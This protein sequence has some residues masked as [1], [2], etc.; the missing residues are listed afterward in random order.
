M[1]DTKF[2][3]KVPVILIITLTKFVIYQGWHSREKSLNF[4]GIPGPG[5]I[6]I[7]HKIINK[8]IK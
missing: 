4:C 2:C 1:D 6:I 8:L 5:I 3:S 7:L